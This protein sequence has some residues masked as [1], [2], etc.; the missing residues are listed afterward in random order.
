MGWPAHAGCLEVLS[1]PVVLRPERYEKKEI[2]A[3]EKASKLVP[4]VIPFEDGKPTAEVEAVPLRTTEPDIAVDI[5]WVDWKSSALGAA[6]LDVILAKTAFRGACLWAKSQAATDMPIALKKVGVSMSAL[7]TN[8]IEVGE[9]VIPFFFRRDASMLTVS[10]TG[11][12]HKEV[13]GTVKWL[14]LIHI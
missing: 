2:P 12:N 13:K 6:A 11:R 14:S 7:A 1:W 5:P 3:A 10:D 9:L 8:D 4:K